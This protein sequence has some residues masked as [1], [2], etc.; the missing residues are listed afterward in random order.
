[1]TLIMSRALK[2]RGFILGAPIAASLGKGFIPVRK[3]G[4]FLVRHSLKVTRW[5]ME[6]IKLKSMSMRFLA[7]PKYYWWMI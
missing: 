6:L 3:V 4:S 1:M 2:A 7:D 5:N